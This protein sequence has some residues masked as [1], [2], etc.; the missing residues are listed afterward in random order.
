VA[1]AAGD[2]ISAAGAAAERDSRTSGDGG[3]GATGRSTSQITTAPPATTNQVSRRDPAERSIR[4]P[5]V[6]SRSVDPPRGL[7]IVPARVYERGLRRPQGGRID[8]PT[9]DL[10]VHLY[11][12]PARALVALLVA[13][14]AGSVPLL[15]ALVAFASDPP[16]LP[17]MLL[18][19]FAL[20]TIVPA[21]AAGAVRWTCRAR[22]RVEDETLVLERRGLRIDV[23]A[24][25]IAGLEPW[26][27]PVPEPALD[28]RLRSG[29]RLTWSVALSD[30][31]QALRRLENTSA[32]GTVAA[33]RATPALRY[34]AARAAGWRRSLGRLVAKFPLFA[35]PVALPLFVTHQWIAYGGPLGQYHLEGPLPFATTLVVYWVTTTIYLALWA[36]LWRGAAE[37]GCLALAVVAPAHVTRTRWV[38]E[39]LCRVVYFA[40]VPILVAMRYL[41]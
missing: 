11:S 7:A 3:E 37:I 8:V 9:T 17:A 13:A 15:A 23:P 6:S 38:A 24:A 16:L 35:L 34:A 19:L 20:W 33:A 39:W 29:R 22:A 26:R 41:A 5:S 4:T 28:V 18:R 21:A 25:A 27:L 36:G 31:N 2:W 10:A 32:S 40:G 12:R 1:R 14:S 30:P